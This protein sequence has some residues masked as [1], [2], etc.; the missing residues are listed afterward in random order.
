M[1]PPDM[2]LIDKPFY[3]NFFKI[4][5]RIK[6]NKRPLVDIV[7]W[8][9]MPNHYHLLVKQL[10]DGGISK[11]INKLANSFTKYFN[12]KND[13]SGYLFQGEFQAKHVDKDEYFNHVSCY[14]HVNHLELSEPDWK[15]KG[16]KDLKIARGFLVDY[17]WSSLRDYLGKKPSMFL[18]VINRD[19]IIDFFDGKPQNY[20]DFIDECLK[21]DAARRLLG[22]FDFF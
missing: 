21:Q 18:P 3:Y 6:D 14:V 8:C 12:I 15:D 20:S 13:R 11:F 10:V 19:I 4:V 17:P 7:A 5:E 16:V 2:N 1:N 22:N 9:L